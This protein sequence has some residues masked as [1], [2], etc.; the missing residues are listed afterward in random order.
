MNRTWNKV[1]FERLSALFGTPF[2]LEL[3]DGLGHGRTPAEIVPADVESSVVAD[4]V[5]QLRWLD[6]VTVA[7]DGR[8]D[9]TYTLNERGRRLFT[10]LESAADGYGAECGSD[11]GPG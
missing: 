4:A 8:G 9:L 5:R 3:I 6:V 11:G 1:D 10:A 2:V 7:D